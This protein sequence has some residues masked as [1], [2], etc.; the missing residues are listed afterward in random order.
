MTDTKKTDTRLITSGRR[1]EW[2]H[3][4]VN[5]PVYRAS[6]CL[7][8][9]YAELRERCADPSAKQLFYGRKGTPTQ[10]ALEEA[11][12]ELEVGA[13]TM[14]YPSGVAAITGAILSL[15]RTG[16]HILITDS[17]YEPTRTFANGLL[18]QMGVEAEYYDPL[19]GDEIKTLFRDNT[20]LVMAESPGSLTFEVQDLPA[21]IETAKEN[22]IFVVVDNTWA[23]PLLLKPLD[24]GADISI[25][26]VTK[27]IGGHSDIMLGSATA[28]ERTFR[29]LQRTAYQ[30]GQTCSPDDA[31]LASRGIRT[32]G[33]RLK[34]HEENALKIAAWLKGRPEVAKV[35]HPAFEDCPGHELWERDFAGS[36]GLFSIIL[37]GGDYPDTAA[38]VDEMTLFKMGFS[39][40][41]YE[42]LILPSDPRDS[43]SVTK[44]EAEGPVVRLHIGLED[45]DDLI[46]ELEA[47]LERYAAHINKQA[48]G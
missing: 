22:N 7:F 2:S 20:R 41:G 26:A 43:R 4:V 15:V 11:I 14:L 30:L 10:W 42:S 5:P 45:T 35:L 40:G 27:Y 33:V 8:E 44:W 16:D 25:H 21:I 1:K 19:I 47:G 9:T 37:K 24:M 6:T 12:T 34:V 48:A 17:A 39:W 46:S 13:G 38:L 23:T 31:F 3:G 32:L 18:R 29:S 28:N 36:S